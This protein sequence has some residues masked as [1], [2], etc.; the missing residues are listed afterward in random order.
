MERIII[1]FSTGNA[2]FDDQPA[3]EIAR[4]LNHIAW[5]FLHGED[6]G[7]IFD[8]NG[9]RVGYVEIERLDLAEDKDQ[10]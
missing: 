10:E 6:V 5:Q 1:Q 9:N 3:T 2:A 7:V 8:K 4:I